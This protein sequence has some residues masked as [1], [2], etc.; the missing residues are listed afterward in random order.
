MRRGTRDATW[1]DFRGALEALT[2]IMGF[3][4]RGS[5]S[6]GKGTNGGK[7]TKENKTDDYITATDHGAN[8]T[9]EIKGT[10]RTIDNKPYTAE[11][12][13]SVRETYYAKDGTEIRTE[14]RAKRKNE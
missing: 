2:I 14:I 3:E 9:K 5:I 7:P 1:I 12:R 4:R 13:D 8:A 11:K 6:K 10:A